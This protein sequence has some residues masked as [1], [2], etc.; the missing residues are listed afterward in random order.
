M[1]DWLAI[2]QTLALENGAGYA[3]TPGALYDR[4]DASL[5]IMAEALLRHMEGTGIDLLALRR[6]G[7]TLIAEVDDAAA[8]EP[9][10][11]AAF[12]RVVRKLSHALLG[13]VWDGRLLVVDPSGPVAGE[14]VVSAP[15]TP[16]ADVTDCAAVSV[17]AF[18][19]AA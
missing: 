8:G 6:E 9:L 14:Q 18:D 16:A 3:V 13:E 1:Q 15:A 7:F 5:A 10:C 4:T 12:N 2:A 19:E 17:P 11:P